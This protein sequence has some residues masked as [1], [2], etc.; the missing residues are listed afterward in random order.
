MTMSGTPRGRRRPG[1]GKSQSH[2][3]LNA[4]LQTA[5]DEGGGILSLLVITPEMLLRAS[6]ARLRESGPQIWAAVQF[7]GLISRRRPLC[8]L[9]EA[10]VTVPRAIAALSACRDDPTTGIASGICARCFARHDRAGQSRRSW[11]S[12]GGAATRRPGCCRRSPIRGTHEASLASRRSTFARRAARRAALI[13]LGFPTIDGG[14]AMTDPLPMSQRERHDL[15][16]LIRA[17]ERVALGDAREYQATLLA[18]FE[19]KIAAIYKPREHP[20]WREAHEAAKAAAADA[21]AK[22]AATFRDLG[23]PED[24]APSLHLLWF[25]RGESACAERRAELRRVARTEAEKRLR[26]A[27]AHIRRVSVEAQERIHATGLTTEAA[28]TMLASLPSAAALMPDLDLDALERITP[29][30]SESRRRVLDD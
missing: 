7:L 21:Q 12:G 29:T 26:V 6:P 16:L 3:A 14:F 20:I 10:T 23:I 1:R 24:W 2:A 5:L 4:T 19:V 9:C 15:L 17:R 11:K 27:E 30:A 28:Q 25:G 13:F 22:V 8:L 18:N